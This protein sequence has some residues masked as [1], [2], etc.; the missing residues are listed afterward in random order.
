M[1]KDKRFVQGLNVEIQE[2]LAAAQ[3]STFTKT[4]EKV[5]RVESARLQVGDFHT[6]KRNISSYT[7]GQPSK[8][9]PPSKMERGMGE[10]RTAGVSREALSRGGRSGQ[11]QV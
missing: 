11:G 8:S 6:K 3:I 10:V 2:G 7:S 1:E 9:A 4:L 5:Q